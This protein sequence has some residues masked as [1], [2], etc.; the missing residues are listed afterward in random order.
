MSEMPL[1]GAALQRMKIEELETEIKRLH[2]KLAGE[3]LRA[4]QG[5]QRYEAANQSRKNLEAQLSAQSVSAVQPVAWMWEYHGKR[6]TLDKAE[7]DAIAA[8]VPVMAL[9]HQ[10]AADADAVDAKRYRWLRTRDVTF[11]GE[12]WTEF[13]SYIPEIGHDGSNLDAAIDAAM[14]Q[15]TEGAKG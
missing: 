9:V 5:W 7:A 3:T 2:I 11:E 4:D 1:Y 15:S 6:V 12:D 13:V 14:A 8:D 10:R